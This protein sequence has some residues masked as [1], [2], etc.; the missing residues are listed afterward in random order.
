MSELSVRKTTVFLTDF[1]PEGSALWRML[2]LSRF[3]GLPEVHENQHHR[4][5]RNPTCRPVPFFTKR[6]WIQQECPPGSPLHTQQVEVVTDLSARCECGYDELSPGEQWLW[7]DAVEVWHESEVRV[8]SL[9]GE[10]RAMVEEEVRR[11]K[12]SQFMPYVKDL[13]Q[14]EYEGTAFREQLDI[15]IREAEVELHLRALEAG[16]EEAVRSMT[17]TTLTAMLESPNPRERSIGIRLASRVL[18]GDVADGGPSDADDAVADWAITRWPVST[19]SCCE[20]DKVRA[21]DVRP[22][23]ARLAREELAGVTWSVS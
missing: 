20:P 19:A 1:F 15:I 7:D 9:Q 17:K 22:S 13:G 14:V 12:A 11:M 3:A 18:G 16:Y 21:G 2:G 10:L 4:M 5:H 23:L 6:T 8:A